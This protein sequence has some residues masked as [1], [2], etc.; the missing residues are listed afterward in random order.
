MGGGERPVFI[1][2]C[3]PANFFL[4]VIAL[5][6]LYLSV[7]GYLSLINVNRKA[8]IFAFLRVGIIMVGGAMIVLGVMWLIE[9]DR[10]RASLILFGA[11]SCAFGMSDSVRHGDRRAAFLGRSVGSVIAIVTAFLVVN[12][13]L[14][15]EY[16]MDCVD[17]AHRSDNSAHCLSHT[18]SDRGQRANRSGRT[19]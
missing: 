10:T 4:F 15:R 12:I 18:T 7:Y 5:F 19:P 9:S 6:T 8:P 13:D 17:C 16:Q 3:H 14:P 11:I 1:A 2:S